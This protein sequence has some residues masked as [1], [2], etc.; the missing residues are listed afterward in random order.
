M[1][2]AAASLAA[3]ER[4]I[5]PRRRQRMRRLLA[6]FRRDLLWRV[7]GSRVAEN[8]LFDAARLTQ[9][10]AP[11]LVPG[12]KCPFGDRSALLINKSY[13]QPQKVAA[14]LL[15]NATLARANLLGAAPCGAGSAM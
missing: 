7:P 12:C 3:I 15:I 14:N 8:I 11:T 1:K 9:A 5:P 10:G 4:A 2:D 6:H 13:Y